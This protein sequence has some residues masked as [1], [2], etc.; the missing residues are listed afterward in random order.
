MEFLSEYALFLLKALTIIAVP[1]LG[2]AIA[3]VLIKLKGDFTL[4]FQ[5]IETNRVW[6]RW[7]SIKKKYNNIELEFCLVILILVHA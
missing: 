4:W 1:L 7:I 5:K 3:S 2:I 6:P